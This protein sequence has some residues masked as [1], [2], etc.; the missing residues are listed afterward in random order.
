VKR[1]RNQLNNQLSQVFLCKSYLKVCRV[2]SRSF[3][4]GG[5]SRHEG[6]GHR[7]R[8][9]FPGPEDFGPDDTFD[10]PDENLRGRDHG[11]RGRGRGAIR[12]EGN[13]LPQ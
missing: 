5:P 13:V 12:G 3:R 8:D 4:R 1:F 2:L 10:S 11:A 9:G 7:G 6:R